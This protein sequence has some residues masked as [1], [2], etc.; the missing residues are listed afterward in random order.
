MIRSC[1]FFL[2]SSLHMFRWEHISEGTFPHAAVH[3][4]QTRNIDSFTILPHIYRKIHL[5]YSFRFFVYEQMKTS[6][7][8]SQPAHGAPTTSLKRWCNVI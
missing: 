6:E 2:A 3:E 7:I 4:V 5:I 8:I 1:V